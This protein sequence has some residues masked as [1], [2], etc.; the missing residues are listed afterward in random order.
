MPSE[1]SEGARQSVAAVISTGVPSLLA[2]ATL[3]GS[4]VA[5]GRYRTEP[6]AAIARLQSSTG[7]CMWH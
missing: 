5:A 1:P 7:L 6:G 2:E 3:G 4:V